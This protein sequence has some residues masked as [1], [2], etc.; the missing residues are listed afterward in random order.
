MVFE[1]GV[2]IH[3]EVTLPSRRRDS[4]DERANDQGLNEE[5]DLLE[6]V[7]NATHLREIAAKQRLAQCYNLKGKQ[8]GFEVTDLVL[9]RV[10]DPTKK[11][12][13]SPNWEGLFRVLEKLKS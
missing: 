4:F 9:K 13:L 1:A 8:R 5:S 7:R 11:G 10:T 2:M 3:V 12:N 6:E